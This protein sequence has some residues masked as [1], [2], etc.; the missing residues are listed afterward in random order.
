MF[1]IG[2]RGALNVGAD[3]DDIPEQGINATNQTTITHVL[4][5]TRDIARNLA[6]R[7]LVLGEG[8]EGPLHPYNEVG[9]A[10]CQG[11]QASNNSV[12]RPDA[13]VIINVV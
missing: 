4:S 6:V 11:C 7:S 9:I 3:T 13:S 2:L 8:V 1:L 12:S 5:I 10:A